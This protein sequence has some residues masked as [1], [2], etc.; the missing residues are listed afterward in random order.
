MTV[1]VTLDVERQAVHMIAGSEKYIAHT[2]TVYSA[3]VFTST[4]PYRSRYFDRMY[5]LSKNLVRFA[6][7]LCVS[8]LSANSAIVSDVATQIPQLL[9]CSKVNALR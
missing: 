4:V 9:F 5:T 6:V 2:A 1:K 3:G 8:P 7:S